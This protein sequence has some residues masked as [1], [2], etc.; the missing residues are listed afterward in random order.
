M[1]LPACGSRPHIWNDKENTMSHA[2]LADEAK[3][4]QAIRFVAVGQP[5]PKVLE[6]FLKAANLYELIV[7]PGLLEREYVTPSS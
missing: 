3:L 1:R 6:D 4:E 5:L 2:D 7:N